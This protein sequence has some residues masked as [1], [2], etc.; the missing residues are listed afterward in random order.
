MIELAG[1][2]LPATDEVW[3]LQG[4]EGIEARLFSTMADGGHYRGAGGT[5]QGIYVCTPSGRLLASCNSLDA[6]AVLATL[7]DGLAAWD[8]V[9]DADRRLARAEA[10]ATDPRWEWQ[11]PEGGLVLR[12]SQRDLPPSGDPH[13]APLPRSNVDHVWFRADEAL[14]FV[15]AEPAPGA[16][17]VVDSALTERLARFHLVDNVRGQTLPFSPGEVAGSRLTSEVVGVEGDALE[18]RLAGRTRAVSDG[19]WELGDNIWTPEGRWP[20][21]L[22][23]RVLGRAVFDRSTGRFTAFELLA[24]GHRAGRTQLNGRRDDEAGPIGFWFE[25]AGD[26]PGD[27]VAP[28]FV[29][30][31]DAPWLEP[32]ASR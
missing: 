17:R 8:A 26:A 24:L 2:F 32:L 21:S 30:V 5:R 9:G 7:R 15:P 10:L 4:G 16:T 20:R 29:H 12:S 28:G 14:G 3:R 19:S 22:E 25:L 13:D 6:D 27:R 11:Y 18:L 23:T 31:Y 1:A